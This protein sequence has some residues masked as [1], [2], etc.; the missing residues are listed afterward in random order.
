M[1]RRNGVREYVVWRTYDEE[2]DYFVLRGDRYVRLASDDDGVY[3]SRAFP[4][5]WLAARRLLAGDL[6]RA[7]T[8]AQRGVASPEH[9]D[10][11]ARLRERAARH[12][13]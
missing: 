12:R 3:R 7:F 13:E 5:L 6:A 11:T 9:A 1:Y 4:G 8:L 2:I 10:F